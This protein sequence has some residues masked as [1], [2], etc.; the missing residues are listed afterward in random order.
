MN[1]S[2]FTNTSS[3]QSAQGRSVRN[4]ASIYKRVLS[5]AGGKE[6]EAMM[7][8]EDQTA[9]YAALYM[10]PPYDLHVPAM[11]VS[12]LSINMTRARVSGG[13][14]GERQR[15]FDAKRHSLFLTPAG[16]PVHWHKESPSRHLNIYFDPKAF[17]RMDEDAPH[18][19]HNE[20]MFNA[21]VP[22]IQRFAN[23]LVSELNLAGIL[24]VEAVDSLARLLLVQLARYQKQALAKAQKLTPIAL[25]RL[26]EYVRENV[27][28]RILVHDL[29]SVVGMSPNR[30]AHVFSEQVG[31]PPHQFVLSHRL[32]LAVTLLHKT[33]QSLAE[34]AANCG[35][36]S[37]QHL[38]HAMRRQFGVTPARFRT[39]GHS[40]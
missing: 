35:F 15:Q 30:F 3:P 21:F 37:Q 38:T 17:G 12:R 24:A 4:G 32:E 34:V 10:S 18:L 26:S 6:L 19:A 8:S 5:N 9:V 29:A 31:K 16:A 39:L 25:A 7:R 14:D 22:G 1:S 36:A 40:N 20:P 27:A 28:E 2:S 23:D 13:L 33:Q 11:Q